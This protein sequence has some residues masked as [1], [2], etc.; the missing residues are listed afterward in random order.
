MRVREVT[1][2]ELAGLDP[3]GMLLMNVNTPDDH[4]RAERHARLTS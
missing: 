4:A 2:K 1:I 3:G